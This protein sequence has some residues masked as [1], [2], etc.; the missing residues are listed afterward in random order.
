MLRKLSGLFAAAWLILGGASALAQGYPQ[1]NWVALLTP[2]TTTVGLLTGQLSGISITS[3][4][5][6]AIPGSTT[7]LAPLTKFVSGYTGDATVKGMAPSGLATDYHI[8]AG[9]SAPTLSFPVTYPGFDTGGNPTT[10]SQSLYAVSWLR[11]AYS[12]NTLPSEATAGSDAKIA[13]AWNDF[14]YQSDTTG[15]ATALAS[16]YK[17]SLATTNIPVT[18]NSTRVYPRPIGGWITEPGLR[19]GASQSFTVEFFVG[20]MYAQG[21]KPVQAVKFIATDSAGTHTVT[22]VISSMSMSARQLSFSCTGTNGSSVLTSCGSTLGA[23]DGMRM[24]VAGIPG[25][26]KLLSH[27]STSLT[28]GQTITSGCTTTLNSGVVS[29]TTTPGVGE[30]FDDGGFVGA[31]IT[32]ANFTTPAGIATIT[33]DPVAADITFTSGKATAVKAT[34]GATGVTASANHTCTINHVFQGTT[35]AVTAYVGVPLPVFSATFA[36]ADFTGASFADGITSFRAQALPIRGD[37]TLD[38]CVPFGTTCATG[39]GADGTG[40]DWQGAAF[41]ANGT[42]TS[43]NLHNLW[44][45]YDSAGKYSPIYAWVSGTAGG[46]PA[47]QSTSTDPGSVAYYANVGTA[48]TAWPTTTPTAGSSATCP[49]ARPTR[50]PDQTS[51]PRPRRNCRA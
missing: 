14:V 46:T 35:G 16:L 41:L 34:T 26:P 19:I 18:N 42:D 25:Q 27:T 23:I 33:V 44:A 32:D 6:P 3:S 31:T 9:P 38:T 17:T 47:V 39:S 13:L 4:V 8:T 49:S 29:L 7:D 28:F 15:N 37:V 12:S 24:T 40:N 45:F 11:R 2:P 50:A 1:I 30:A 20:H 21:G 22:K 51:R 36:A 48:T 5:W 10:G 43:P